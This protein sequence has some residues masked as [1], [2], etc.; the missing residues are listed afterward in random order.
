MAGGHAFRLWVS[1]VIQSMTTALA[2]AGFVGGMPTAII[3]TSGS[4]DR[5]RRDLDCRLVF[6]LVPAAAIAAIAAAGVFSSGRDALTVLFRVR[7]F[8][9]RQVGENAGQGL[10]CICEQRRPYG[11]P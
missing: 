9:T 8:G 3:A 11:Q 10:V 1:S 4:T 6:F 7:K 2:L 5:C